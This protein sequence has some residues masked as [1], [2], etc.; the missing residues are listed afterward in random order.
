MELNQTTLRGILAQIFSIDEKYIVPKQGNWWN[1]QEAHSNI[2]NYVSYL[3][4]N[5]RP[6]TVPFYHEGTENNSSV[7][8]V[9][10]EKI[11]T[12]ELQFVGPDSESLAQSVSVWPYRSDVAAQFRAVHGAIMNNNMS[13]ESSVFYQ[14]GD[15]TVMAWNVTIQVIW[16]Y[17]LDTTQG[18]VHNVIF[19]N[20]K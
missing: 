19:T 15:N 8:A 10:T 1:P 20:T 6:R 12:I 2:N 4:R 7:N 17:L 14:D 3:I 5:N 9:A 13:A 16:V 18:Q 11:A